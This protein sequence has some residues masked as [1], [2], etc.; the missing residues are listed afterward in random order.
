MS[1]V[2][3]QGEYQNRFRIGSDCTAGERRIQITAMPFISI[4]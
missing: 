2:G 3:D 1:T 4:R